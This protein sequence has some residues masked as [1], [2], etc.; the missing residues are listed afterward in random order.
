MLTCFMFKFRLPVSL[1][2][3]ASKIKKPLN[4]AKSGLSV[5]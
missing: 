5:D 1:K 2:T 4:K 3:K